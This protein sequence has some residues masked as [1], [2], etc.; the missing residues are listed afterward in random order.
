LDQSAGNLTS[1]ACAPVAI[2]IINTKTDSSAFFIFLL[3]VQVESRSSIE[4]R[5][6]P[7]GV[8]DDPLSGAD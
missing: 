4:D 3:P 7:K 8:K 2:E 5:H 1:A 6:D